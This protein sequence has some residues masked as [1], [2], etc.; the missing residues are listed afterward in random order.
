MTFTA[1][2]TIITAV[3]FKFFPFCSSQFLLTILGVLFTR[4]PSATGALWETQSKDKFAAAGS[5][6]DY[7][8]AQSLNFIRN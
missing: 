3:V 2:I 7:H 4:K 5:P 1:I 6:K 8:P